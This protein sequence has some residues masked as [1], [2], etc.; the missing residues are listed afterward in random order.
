MGNI[1]KQMRVSVKNN[2]TRAM[3]FLQ[4][5]EFSLIEWIKRYTC[6]SLI[7]SSKLLW[8][9]QVEKKMDGANAQLLNEYANFLRDRLNRLVEL[10]KLQSD[11]RQKSTIINLIVIYQNSLEIILKL[12]ALQ[13]ININSFE[14]QM[15]LRYYQENT[16]HSFSEFDALQDAPSRQNITS[17]TLIQDS[18]A[19]PANAT[20]L[21][22]AVAGGGGTATSIPGRGSASLSSIIVR[23]SQADHPFGYEYLG[24]T[25]RLVITP[26]TDKC[27]ITLMAAMK[28]NFGGAPA[29]KLPSKTEWGGN[30]KKR[31]L[32]GQ[33]GLPQELY[34]K[35][36]IFFFAS[37]RN[38][39]DP[40]FHL[41]HEKENLKK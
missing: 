40:R 14:W 32:I 17:L 9:Y 22:P 37:T 12:V 2:I 4:Q 33:K 31:R 13:D 5:P 21:K 18:S 20:S 25:P 7:I 24:N 8:T 34:K 28:Y 29:G 10:I 15:Q 11:L 38:I 39:H 36:F 26:L 35:L 1:E 6:M 27:Y 19:T 30:I 16:S 41:F 23:C 3:Y